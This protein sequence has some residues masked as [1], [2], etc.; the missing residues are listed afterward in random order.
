MLLGWKVEMG[1]MEVHLFALFYLENDH[2]NLLKLGRVL[3]L[4]NFS[5]KDIQKILSFT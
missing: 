1:L 3:A 2:D 4:A 5:L